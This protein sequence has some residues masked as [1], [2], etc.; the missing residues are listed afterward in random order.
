[1]KEKAALSAP[2]VAARRVGAFSAPPATPSL[3][4]SGKAGG[5]NLA[6][7]ILH[8]VLTAVAQGRSA[9][10]ILPLLTEKA[11]TLTRCASAAIALLEPDNESALFVAA[12]GGDAADLPGSRV[13]LTDTLMGNTART[14]EPYLAFR[15]APVSDRAEDRTED[16]D[17]ETRMESAAAMAI[18]ADGKPIGA[19]AVQNK[20]GNQPFDGADFLALS[21]LAA[22]ASVVLGNG[23]LREQAQRQ[24]REL[25][26]LHEA[27]RRISG[28]LTAQE[29]LRAVVEQ[30]A[31]HLEHSGVVVFL[32]NDERTHLYIAED[33]G[34]SADERE[35]ALPTDSGIGAGLLNALQPLFLRFADTQSLFPPAN[36]SGILNAESLFP[37]RADRAALAAPIRHDETTQGVVL[38]LSQQPSGVYT[39]ADAHFLAALAGQAAV[40]ME[41]AILYEDATQRAEEATALYELS[42]A[43]NSTLQLPEI[44]ERVAD[45]ALSLLSVDKFALF[46]HDRTTDYLDLV[47]ERGLPPNAALRLRPRRG[48]GIPGW[49]MEF[50][51][52]TAVQDVAADHRNAAAP[53]HPEGVVSLTCM[54]LQVG[55]ATIGVLAAMSGRR[56]LFTVAEMELLYTIANQAAI[57]IENARMYAEANQRSRKAR[58]Y[59]HQV[60]RA[61]AS[62]EGLPQL[63]ASLTKEI[64]NADRCALHTVR[65]AANGDLMLETAATIGFRLAQPVAGL[66]SAPEDSPTGWI[67]RHGRPLQV[68][69]LDADPRF[70]P[71]YE[72]PLRGAVA[73]YLGVPLRFGEEIIGVLE[74]YA[75]EPRRWQTDAVRTLLTFA[76]QAAV[77]FQNA[78]LAE[79][80]ERTKRIARLY[81]RL[82]EMMRQ[83]DPPRA[84]EV[85]ALLALNLNAPVATLYRDA[86]ARWRAGPA[87]VPADAVPVVA[88]TVALENPDAE[89]SEFRLAVAPQKIEPQVA[90]ALL[91]APGAELFAPQ[92]SLLETAAALLL[93]ARP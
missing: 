75:R 51:T 46:L 5:A 7:S 83:T 34:L 52:P 31:A 89:T 32:V 40:A 29:A 84:E 1:M 12:S 35:I 20:G 55:A 76:L 79:E 57:A 19:F 71:G 45:A 41:N 48:E 66:H 23:R 18:F 24:Q 78:R 8:E 15:T 69:N 72:R 58:R 38:I 77:A 90:I 88:L 11:R 86:D 53:L 21:T 62:P 25:T 39:A 54:P 68:E 16:N 85:V 81:E 14:G 33:S 91:A 49:V 36:E 17:G 80:S 64:M 63:L 65:R 73:S 47:V 43:V 61:L 2:V 6:L 44:L 10:E 82:M 56:R 87:S 37:E 59:F 42:Q 60:A 30:A 3:A 4:V 50:E 28:N 67:A 9:D 93:R 13:L 70:A 27:V 26:L 74:V 92:G 22:A